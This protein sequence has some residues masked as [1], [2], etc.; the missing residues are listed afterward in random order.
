VAEY[1]YLDNPFPAVDPSLYAS[2]APIQS[3]KV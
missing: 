1:E 2:H 3:I